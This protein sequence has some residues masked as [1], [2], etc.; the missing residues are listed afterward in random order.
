MKGD[1]TKKVPSVNE[2]TTSEI[3]NL[4]KSTSHSDDDYSIEEILT[5][6]DTSIK[7]P[8]IEKKNEE[9]KE[10][11]EEEPK[12]E[13]K[14]KE[15]RKLR[16]GELIFI[17][18]NIFVIF[19]IIGF[20]GYRAYYFYKRE[21]IDIVKT[22][23]LVDVV[24][25]RKNLAIA[26]DG[27]YQDEKDEKLFYYK[28]KNVNNNVLF[29]GRSWKIIEINK[30][31]IKLIA[32]ENVSS[33]VYG[34]NNTYD[35]SVI[36]T[37]L[38]DYTNSFQDP[39]TNL[40]KSKW[41]SDKVDVSNY[42]CEKTIEDYVGLLSIDDYLRAGGSNSYLPL[43]DYWWTINYDKDNYGYYVN[44]KGQIN[45]N[46]GD[47]GN[48]FSF[49]VR[50]V[51][52]I[53][54]DV[55]Y[56]SGTGSIGSPYVVGTL[57]NVVLHDNYVGNY[58]MYNDM[59]FRIIKADESGTEL[60]LDSVLDKKSNFTNINATLEK[61][62]LSKFDKKD[63]IKMNYSINKYSFA[64]KYNYKE[65]YSKSSGYVRIPSIGDYYTVGSST[66]WV[67]NIYDST[68]GLYYTIQD[69]NTYFSDLKAS[70]NN[71]KPIIKVNPD[72]IVESGSGTL[73]N[74]FIIG[75]SND[76]VKK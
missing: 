24:T 32:S 64:N 10:V 1:E 73:A 61:D 59:L 60:I 72:I 68:L 56:K 58:V 14:K 55:Y 53:P 28:G 23:P 49:G 18:G 45:N 40:V 39:E 41:C 12:E 46:A 16:N 13:K 2:E 50:P 15:K 35:K 6:E 8:K 34:L 51:I 43:E 67:N 4:N 62:F 5:M 57:K 26:G 76:E 21:N 70:N 17:L 30:D 54:R 48:Y 25:A 74:P 31:N 75:G 38:K 66:Y 29:Q 52:T 9:K 33:I 65:V 47:S 42:K 11:K 37:W 27:L 19:C 36:K 3:D 71:I 63:L 44:D 20:Y 22:T 7:K 69:N